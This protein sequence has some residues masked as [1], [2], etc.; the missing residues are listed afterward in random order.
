M[1]QHEFDS[2]MRRM[3]IDYLNLSR[4][5]DLKDKKERIL[6]RCLEILPGFLSWGT[7]GTVFFLSWLKPVAVAIFIIVF[8]LYWLL[9]IAYLSFH[10]ISSFFQMKKNLKTNWIEKLN[11]LPNWQDIHHLVILPMYKEN[12]AIV[13]ATFQSLVDAEY[14]K[15]KIII[16]LAIEERAGKDAREVA[17]EIEKEFSEKFF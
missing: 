12:I 2:R 9:R 11:D 1:S 6:Y 16:V 10:Q 14:P 8:D 3:E 4:A 7:L 5:Q 17:K 13:R 15:E